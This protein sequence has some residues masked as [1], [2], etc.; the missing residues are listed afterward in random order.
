MGAW[1]PTGLKTV[2]AR[3]R[4]GCPEGT[5]TGPGAVGG[6]LPAVFVAVCIWSF[7]LRASNHG[8]I[9]FAMQY[10]L[11]VLL[12]VWQAL[13]HYLWTDAFLLASAPA[14]PCSLGRTVP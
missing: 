13:L 14:W 10:H 5:G 9:P 2:C 4:T 8:L 7:A 3:W 11:P 1:L 6:A 12:I